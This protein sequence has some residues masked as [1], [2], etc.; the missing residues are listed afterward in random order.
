MTNPFLGEFIENL[1]INF[2]GILN[3]SVWHII[4]LLIIIIYLAYTL[5]ITAVRYK[6]RFDCCL[7]TQRPLNKFMLAA[8]GCSGPRTSTWMLLV[9]AAAINRNIGEYSRIYVTQIKLSISF[10]SFSSKPTKWRSF[11]R[12]PISSLHDAIRHLF[13]SSTGWYSML[14]FTI[15]AVSLSTSLESKPHITKSSESVL[16]STVLW[17]FSQIRAKKRTGVLSVVTSDL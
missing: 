6:K 2:R 10:I 17:S 14:F 8:W 1:D 5:T 15:E 4:L 7:R 16:P 3:Y 12:S 9:D 11:C 13:S